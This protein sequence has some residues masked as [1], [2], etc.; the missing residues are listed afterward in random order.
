MLHAV[1]LSTSQDES[2][3]PQSLVIELMVQ[4]EVVLSKNIAISRM[5]GETR[6]IGEM[7]S[8]GLGV[9]LSGQLLEEQ[10][11]AGLLG[12]EADFAKGQE[13]EGGQ[14]LLLGRQHFSFDFTPDELRVVVIGKTV[15]GKEKEIKTSVAVGKYESPIQYQFP[16]RWKLADDLLAIHTK[17]PPIQST[18]GI[19]YRLFPGEW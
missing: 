15:N 6:G 7:V 5:V 12:H 2:F 18:H 9:F 14:F 8:L 16:L 3:H 4:D 11:I 10:G 19:R 17:P 13:L 1:V